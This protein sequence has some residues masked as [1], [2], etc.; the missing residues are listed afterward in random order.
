MAD[1][2][3]YLII[4]FFLSAVFSTSSAKNQTEQTSDLL[5]LADMRSL[6]IRPA[7]GTIMIDAELDDAGW[8][9]ATRITGFIERTPREGAEP[10]VR[11]EVLLTYDEM[12]LYV[13]FI[14]SDPNPD[15]IRA[16]LQPRDQLWRDDW[17][18][19]LL[20][21]YGDASLGYYFLSNPI[22]VQGDLQM[23][24]V[25]E[26]VSID[27]VYETAGRI[28]NDGF[29]VEMAIPFRSLRISSL[30]VQN[31][32]IM[33]VRTYPRSSR[34]YLTWPSWSRNNPCQLCEMAQLNG[35]EDIRTG[36]NLEM[37]PSLIAT[38]AG[39]LQNPS[40]P[41]SF[42]NGRVQLQPSLGLK[43]MF[44]PGWTAEATLNP[45]FSQVESDATQI[46]VN[47]TFALF[48]PERRPFF[49]EGMDL[50]QTPM[51]VF[52]SRSINA[53]AVSAKLT[54]R[55]DRTSIGYIGAR[56]DHSP[57]IIPFEEQTVVLQGGK[58]YTN[59]LRL[60]HNLQ[61]SHVGA[62]V[63]D[64]RL[65]SGGSGTTASVDGLYRFGEMYNLSAH[66]IFSYTNEPDDPELSTQ[67][68]DLNFDTDGQNFSAAFDGESFS[69]H[70]GFL[71]FA[72]DARTWSWNVLYMEASP[73]YRADTGFQSQNNFR[74]ATG[75][76]GLTFYPNK[77]LLERFSASLFGGS[78]WNFEGVRNQ[79]IF[80]PG[81]SFSLPRQIS[82]GMD[83]ELRREIFRGTELTGI[84][85]FYLRMN[86]NFSAAF[87]GGLNFSTGRRIARTLAIPEV[88]NGKTATISAYI[89][90]LQRFVIQP[91]VS[92]QQ[93]NL[94]S[95]E[96]IFSGYIARTRFS[97]QFNRELN[98][99]TIFQ[100]NDFQ[101][102][103]DIEPLLVYQ[104]N[105]FSIFYIGSTYGSVN[106]DEY[107]FSGTDRQYF[108]KFQYL[109]RY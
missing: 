32:G 13:A 95:G 19:I 107:G 88:G 77:P 71:R 7:T 55:S 92:Y 81:V 1:Y 12:N 108:A 40:D 96:E 94:D 97:F 84:R 98:L 47:T 67:I 102:R 23:T 79:D 106:F 44:Q 11:T 14:A 100:Y 22:G 91:S 69:G 26:D 75:W 27:F 18:G 52:Y 82:I 20:D 16:A 70:A 34:H 17:V 93:L 25:N 45:D 105:P 41:V 68:P 15:E 31:W 3:T 4:L 50:Y 54:G 83:L 30:D 64:R 86:S 51:S 48:F 57:F 85:N 10:P 72:R 101:N 59:V 87:Q 6:D 43:Y 21:P 65:D 46:D 62:M 9:N 99:R 33:F 28:T 39:Q 76:T 61:G 36:G 5:T 58:S 66:L 104:L 109:I 63:T 60:Q 89:T 78:Y 42:E 80:Q 2:L 53:P 37:L 49:Q 56:D 24:P 74:R 103:L 35:I 38:Q 8:K 29:I 73:T 90:P